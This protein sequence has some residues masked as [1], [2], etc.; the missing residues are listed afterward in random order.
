MVSRF[1]RDRDYFGVSTSLKNKLDDRNDPR[2]DRF[3]KSYAAGATEI[4]FAP[5]G[6]PEQVQKKY[7]ISALTNTTN[8]TRLI[9]YHEIQFLK[10]EAYARMSP[11]QVENAES[12][13]EEAIEAA[14]VK[15]GLTE[16]EASAY[17]DSSVKELFDEN[18]LKEIMTQ[19]YLAL[20]DE[21]GIEIYNDYRRLKAMGDEQIELV[22]KNNF[23]LRFTY[24]TSDVTTNPNVREAYG[25][26]SYVYN[27]NVWWAGGTR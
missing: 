14:F 23:P 26:G 8:P 16:E 25:D 3:F 17:Y 10:A 13:L 4:L 22:N 18:P 9:S 20:Y 12:A 1:L 2:V 5:N 27:E 7:G 19:K 24:G 21:E 11:A 15:V 6:E